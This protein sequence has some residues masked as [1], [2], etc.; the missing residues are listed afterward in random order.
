MFLSYQHATVSIAMEPTKRILIIQPFLLAS[1]T[2]F[3][4]IALYLFFSTK[5]PLVAGN[6]TSIGLAI[7]PGL[8]L[9]FWIAG[10]VWR[11]LLF[12]SFMFRSRLTGTLFAADVVL[13]SWNTLM[14]IV[15]FGERLFSIMP[16]ILAVCVALGSLILKGMCL[17]A[18]RRIQKAPHAFPR[19]GNVIQ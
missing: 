3:L 14:L 8:F 18:Y 9:A 2:V 4:L 1:A 7:T 19:V 15:L 6:A 13:A 16:Y 5:N 17:S 12:V 11:T 10:V